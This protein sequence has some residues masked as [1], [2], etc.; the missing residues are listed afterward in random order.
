MT[1]LHADHVT[2]Y[3]CNIFRS[4]QPETVNLTAAGS[5]AVGPYPINWRVAPLWALVAAGV[6]GNTLV[7]ASIVVER[8]LQNVTN[9]FLVSLAVADL[10]VS[11]VVMPCCIVQEIMGRVLFV[12]TS[13]LLRAHYCDLAPSRQSV[14]L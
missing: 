9:Y 12:H 11:L 8:R 14:F 4:V 6:T 3:D 10:F 1:S 7:C 5:D 2:E 13:R